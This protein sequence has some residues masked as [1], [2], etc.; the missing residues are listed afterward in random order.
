MTLPLSTKYL[1]NREA[2]S[3]LDSFPSP[4]VT[5][6]TLISG[7]VTA[8]CPVTGQ[9]DFYKVTITY[10]PQDLCLESKSLKLYLQSFRDQAMF[11][12]SMAVKITDDIMKCLACQ[13][14]SVVVFQSPRGGISIES[15]KTLFGGDDPLTST[16]FIRGKE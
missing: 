15:R 8:N 2:F 10:T 13:M 6:V 3:G 16:S 1:G 14:V 4:G 9:P 12:E 5:S 7:E 11:G